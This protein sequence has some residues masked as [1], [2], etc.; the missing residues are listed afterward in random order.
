MIVFLFVAFELT[1]L[2]IVDRQWIINQMV[3]VNTLELLDTVGSLFT[4]IFWCSRPTYKSEWT[5]IIS[6]MVIL[7]L[8]LIFLKNNVSYIPA[9]SNEY[10]ML[11]TLA[12][13]CILGLLLRIS[14]LVSTTE[15]TLYESRLR[16]LVISMFFF[17]FPIYPVLILSKFL[18][19][20]TFDLFALHF[21]VLLSNALIPNLKMLI[22]SIPDASTILR[23]AYGYTPIGLLATAILQLRGHP[24][25]VASALLVWVTATSLAVIA[26]N[27]FPITGPA[28]VFNNINEAFLHSS[29]YPLDMVAPLNAPRNGMPSMHFGWM[30]AATILWWQSGSGQYS[31]FIMIIQTVLVAVA[32]LYFGEHYVIDLIVAVPFILSSIALCTTMISIHSSPRKYTILVGFL[33]WILWVFLLRTQME[34]FM[35][36]TWSAQGLVAFTLLISGWQISLLAKFKQE[37]T[38]SCNHALGKKQPHQ[39][40]SAIHKGP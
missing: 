27:F 18:H 20:K 25:H 1:I 37:I 13:P 12:I 29:S 31:R 35:A 39:V 22:N 24:P 34:F 5:V 33:T 32:T 30:L 28:Y 7:F 4:V 10:I 40:A 15:S 23:Y 16:W 21:D 14:G 9:G 38:V 6:W 8:I 17:I 19:V 11:S 36:H 3:P 2:P 26:Y